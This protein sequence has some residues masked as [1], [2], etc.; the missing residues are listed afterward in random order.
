MM[1][2]ARKREQTARRRELREAAGRAIVRRGVLGLRV[3]DVAAEA[4]ISAGLVS[5][6]YPD[7]DDL[8]V[9]LH[10]HSVDRFYWSR[11]AVVEG[12]TDSRTR[13]VAL[14]SGGL[15]EGPDDQ[16][17]VIL[18][19]LHLHAARSRTHAALMTSLWDREVSLYTMVLQEGHDRGELTLRAPAVDVASTAVALEDAFG[20]HIVA[21]N[22]R[23]D[24]DRARSLL[25][26]F[27]SD[28]TGV[29]LRE[30][31]AHA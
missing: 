11:M 5:Y 16:L 13:L 30:E 17:C 28:A 14:A 2:M 7:L 24:V 20:L 15:P 23:L 4:G 21:R 26:G 10:E 6:Y 27:L 22:R 19:E 8:L 1:L 3:K 31:D 12:A 25:T 18:Y 29:T 9:D